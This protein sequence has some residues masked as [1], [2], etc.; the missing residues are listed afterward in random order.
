[1]IEVVAG[2]CPRRKQRNQRKRG[3]QSNPQL[4]NLVGISALKKKKN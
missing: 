2:P 4:L 1:M 3:K